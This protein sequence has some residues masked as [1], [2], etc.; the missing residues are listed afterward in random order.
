LRDFFDLLGYV[1]KEFSGWFYRCTVD[2]LEFVAEGERLELVVGVFEVEVAEV[3][4]R[5]L[6]T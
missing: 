6:S 2:Y 4:R 5:I 3:F 1:C